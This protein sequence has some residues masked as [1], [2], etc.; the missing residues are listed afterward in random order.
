[1]TLDPTGL[2][3]RSDGDAAG[4][5]DVSISVSHVLIPRAPNGTDHMAQTLLQSQYSP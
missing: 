2:G 3:F 4:D 1:M 5:G